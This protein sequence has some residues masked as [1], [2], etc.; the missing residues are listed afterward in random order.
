[1]HLTDANPSKENLKSLAE[2]LSHEFQRQSARL[3]DLELENARRERL[4]YRAAC[5]AG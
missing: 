2:Q 4:D 1:M 3:Q 5:G